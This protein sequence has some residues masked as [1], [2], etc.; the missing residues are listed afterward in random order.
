MEE[1]GWGYK[2]T[3]CSV[4][5]RSLHTG[6]E[7]GVGGGDTSGFLYPMHTLVFYHIK[8]ICC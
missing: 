1:G 4:Q 8:Y 2:S 7:E 6:G 5:E 3:N